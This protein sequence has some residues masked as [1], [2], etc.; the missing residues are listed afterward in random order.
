M[1]IGLEAKEKA[2]KIN[3][4]ADK[5]HIARRNEK[6]QTDQSRPHITIQRSW[7][8]GPPHGEQPWNKNRSNNEKGRM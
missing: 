8:Y 2:K 6:I 5:S 3:H 4:E 1:K 7:M